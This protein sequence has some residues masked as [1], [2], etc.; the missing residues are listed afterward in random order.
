MHMALAAR[1]VAGMSGTDWDSGNICI[2]LR[3]GGLSLGVKEMTEDD[4]D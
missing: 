2:S 1:S 3:V 4:D